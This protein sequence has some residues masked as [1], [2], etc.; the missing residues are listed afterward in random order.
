MLL[1]SFER[2]AADDLVRTSWSPVRENQCRAQRAGKAV[3]TE[4]AWLEL[5]NEDT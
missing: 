2:E 5:A 4:H 3:R 1:L